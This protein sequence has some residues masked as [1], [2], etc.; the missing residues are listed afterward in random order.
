M[1]P[2]VADIQKLKRKLRYLCK[3]YG[4]TGS[5]ADKIFGAVDASAVEAPVSDHN[6]PPREGH[7]KICCD[8]HRDNWT[9]EVD[10]EFYLV[11]S[12]CHRMVWDVN[13]MD[14]MNLNHKK[15][16]EAYPYCHCGAKM[17]VDSRE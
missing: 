6:A 4:I 12:E 8:T 1:T 7:W 17:E 10:E 14:A 9:G 2:K 5:L 16:V 11:C 3:T 15:I 13:Q